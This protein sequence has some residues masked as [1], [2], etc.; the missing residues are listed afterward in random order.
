MNTELQQSKRFNDFLA[1]S[2]LDHLRTFKMGIDFISSKEAKQS[3]DIIDNVTSKPIDDM[4]EF[5]NNK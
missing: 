3:N 2:F 4:Y 5:V 1:V